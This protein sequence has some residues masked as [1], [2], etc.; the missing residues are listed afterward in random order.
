MTE[1][2]INKL[3]IIITLIVTSFASRY[4]CKAKLQPQKSPHKVGFLKPDRLTFYV[5]AEL[6]EVV[7]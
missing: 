2:M 5:I 7:Q 3:F 1:S 4:K 6:R